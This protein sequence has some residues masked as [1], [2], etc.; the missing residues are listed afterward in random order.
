[1]NEKSFF[2]ARADDANAIFP[3]FLAVIGEFCI[4]QQKDAHAHCHENTAGSN[5]ITMSHQLLVEVR[6]MAQA[7]FVVFVGY[8]HGKL[9]K[10]ANPVGFL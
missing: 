8:S 10:S 7:K 9:Y 6:V 5:Y 1:M 2:C 4:W 3:I